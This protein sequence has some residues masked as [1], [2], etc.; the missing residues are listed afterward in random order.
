MV[1][2]ERKMQKITNPTMI[3]KRNVDTDVESHKSTKTEKSVVSS[4]SLKVTKRTQAS[5]V[6]VIENRN[7]TR[8]D[9]DE[10]K[11][12]EGE[13]DRKEVALSESS[14]SKVQEKHPRSPRLVKKSH[15]KKDDMLLCSNQS[16][17]DEDDKS[18]SNDSSDMGSV[19]S[20]SMAGVSRTLSTKSSGTKNT[21]INNRS[22]N[23]KEKVLRAKHE[24]ACRYLRSG[25]LE[26]AQEK[27]EEILLAL[28]SEYGK[29]HHR[30]GAA[31]H[32]IGIVHLRNGQLDDAIDAI[33]EA[34]RIR[35]ETLGNY[36]PKVADS[37]VELGIVLLSQREFED[38][39]EIFNEALEMRERESSRCYD[40]DDKKKSNL[41]I[42]KILNNI[43]CVYFEYGEFID[44]KDT[45][46]E[47]L[48][49]Q[50]DILSE[51]EITDPV[52]LAMA[53][54]LCNLGYSCLEERDWSAAIKHLKEA[55]NI[56]RCILEPSNKLVMNTLQNLCFAYAKYCDH[57][58][59]I[60]YNNEILEIQRSTLDCND[61]AIVETLKKIVYSHLKL[62]NY[63]K[64]LECLL[65]TERIQETV[66]TDDDRSLEKT[67]EL[68]SSVHYQILKFPG[69]IEIFM[70]ALTKNGLRNPLNNTT[71]SC[72]L[73][74]PD[75]DELDLRPCVPK[76]PQVSSKM[77]GH[78][79]SYA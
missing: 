58:S 33:E 47:A 3:S 76:R 34:V 62:Y 70:R 63:E 53:S 75:A 9:I 36:H 25:R 40:E 30:V 68:L 49:I 22:R 51:T 10:V 14:F 41:Q 16:D 29:S 44:A 50:R 38:S 61:L 21:K 15:K 52:N 55:L 19:A 73:V 11:K 13:D 2:I 20:E 6:T 1:K 26:K 32:N 54:T 4:R 43:G 45:Y 71:C 39:L 46:D 65:E 27:F 8:D 48:E 60:K 17:D 31:L 78:K 64:A 24:N 18:S 37:L 59:A 57:D 77:S 66:L 12:D 42:A 23:G 28:M 79:V 5:L 72:A 74:D 56:Q 67:R 35:K 69:P 7:E